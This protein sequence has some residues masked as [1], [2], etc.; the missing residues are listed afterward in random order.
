MN[1]VKTQMKTEIR[2][3]GFEDP[4]VREVLQDSLS[5]DEI[6]R[7][8]EWAEHPELADPVIGLLPEQNWSVRT[9]LIFHKRLIAELKALSA[10]EKRA[11]AIQENGQLTLVAW[12]V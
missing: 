3:V 4:D 1:N 6:E 9:E 5:I 11:N 8:A 10:Q 7:L 2:T 12:V